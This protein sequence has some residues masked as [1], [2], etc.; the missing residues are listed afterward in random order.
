M[1]V[2]ATSQAN[3]HAWLFIMHGGQLI[4]FLSSLAV[5]IWF[6]GTQHND[7]EIMADWNS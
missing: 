1:Q 2:H 6:L 3:I 4:S 7:C 5:I